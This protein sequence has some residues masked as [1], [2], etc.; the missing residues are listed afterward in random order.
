M[1]FKET[2]KI[3]YENE[4]KKLLIIPLLLLI[5]AIGQIG[6][7]IATT[8]DFVQRSV[9]LKGG[10]SIT[11]PADI[12]SVQQLMDEAKKINNKADVSVRALRNTNQNIIEIS[13]ITEEQVIQVL[14]NQ[15]VDREKVVIEVTGSTIGKSFFRATIGALA[16]SFILMA[17]VVF[18]SFRTFISSMAVILAAASDIIITLAIFN[19]TGQ[20][21]TTAGIAAFLMLI[22]YSVD[23]DILLSTR[24]LK[25]KEGTTNERIYS[26]I[27]TGLMTT[28]TTIIAVLLALLM[29]KSETIQQIMLIILIGMMVD[30]VNTWIQNVGILRWYIEK[31]NSTHEHQNI[32]TMPTPGGHHG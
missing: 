25:R 11:T 4:Y 9:S 1:G 29:A 15:N 32:N 12:I 20:K 27:K 3:F 8:G 2:I 23:T 21:L 10:I 28:F 19:M 22:G 7:Q 31:K 24:V 6:Y 26:S 16:I 13:D 18:I 17:I 5:L 30:L 14:E